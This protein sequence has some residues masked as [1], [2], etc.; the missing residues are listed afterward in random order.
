[1]DINKRTVGLQLGATIKTIVKHIHEAFAQAGEDVTTG[2][3]LLL[4]LL[5][6]HENLTQQDLSVLLNKDK[7]GVLRQIDDLEKKMLV[8]RLPNKDDRR[9][10]ILML[11][12]KGI[13]TLHKLIEIEGAV[14][15]KFLADVTEE[16]LKIL[17]NILNI[18]SINEAK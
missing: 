18:V 1:M 3:F 11:T 2:Q 9:K 15:E 6:T 13:D 5:D 12:K 8:V 7:S 16:Q 4:N 14:F 17:H 10:K